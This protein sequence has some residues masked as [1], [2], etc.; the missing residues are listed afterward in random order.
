MLINQSGNHFK[1]KHTPQIIIPDNLQR[2]G[3]WCY[4]LGGVA[5]DRE[6]TI[7]K[8]QVEMTRYHFAVR[9]IALVGAVA[10]L[11]ITILGYLFLALSATQQK[12]A[13][14][15][16]EI[17]LKRNI[18]KEVLPKLLIDNPNL[19]KG[20]D[21]G[22]LKKKILGIAQTQIKALEEKNAIETLLITPQKKSHAKK[23]I[24]PKKTP[25]KD[26]APTTPKEKTPVKDMN[27]PVQ[28]E[29][30]TLEDTII[31]QKASLR[32][33]GLPE[34]GKKTKTSAGGVLGLLVNHPMV[35][36]AQSSDTSS[37]GSD[38]GE[39]PDTPQKIALTPRKN[40]K[41]TPTGKDSPEI[42][43]DQYPIDLGADDSPTKKFLTRNSPY[44][45]KRIFT[46]VS[47]SKNLGMRFTSGASKISASSLQ[48]LSP[49]ISILPD[50]VTKQ[51]T[52]RRSFIEPLDAD[53]DKE[54][55]DNPVN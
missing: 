50:D 5:L 13:L 12:I 10:L 26:K 1:I 7:S 11:P 51:I 53:Y 48:V 17:F 19:V 20:S 35:D 46:P 14:L 54:W 34:D 44:K 30:K 24:T 18:K 9:I 6:V 27:E 8:D 38:Q 23:K 31:N 47:T 33:I 21:K 41:L 42:E 22:V 36:T 28:A 3:H 15:A 4:L 52:G 55:E 16:L 2:V 29:S 49:V 37:E 40:W 32:K 43:R 39:W 45:R 25:T